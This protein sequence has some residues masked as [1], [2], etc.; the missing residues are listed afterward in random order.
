MDDPGDNTY[1]MPQQTKRRREMSGEPEPA[2]LTCCIFVVAALWT[3]RGVVLAR[4]LKSIGV[5]CI[6]ANAVAHFLASCDIIH[7][8][9]QY[10]LDLQFFNDTGDKR[11]NTSFLYPIKF[12]HIKHMSMI[13]PSFPSCD[14]LSASPPWQPLAAVSSKPDCYPPDSPKTIWQIQSLL[15]PRLLY[16]RPECQ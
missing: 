1:Q 4:C 16:Q 8:S 13:S 3:R 14:S 11:S 5:I 2:G 15:L 10:L 9:M 12:L 6:T 7:R